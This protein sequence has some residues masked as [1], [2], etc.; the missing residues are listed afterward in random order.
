M[1]IY[2]L[3]GYKAKRYLPTCLGVG[4]PGYECVEVLGLSLHYSMSYKNWNDILKFGS[5]VL[6]VKK[7]EKRL[8]SNL[9][10]TDVLFRLFQ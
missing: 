1:Y 9:P 3:N 10:E 4:F 5:L 6:D 2:C 8:E 7:V